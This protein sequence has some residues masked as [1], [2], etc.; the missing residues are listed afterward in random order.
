M[1]TG[2]SKMT[3]RE[4]RS[5]PRCHRDTTINFSYFN[6]V[7]KYSALARNYCHSGMYFETDRALATGVIILIRPEP[8]PENMPD[9]KSA[10]IY[11]TSRAADSAACQE[12]KTLVTAQ[13]KRCDKLSAESTYR[14]G[15]AVEYVGPSL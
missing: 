3:A 1:I 2:S 12:L 8:C 6:R 14:Y 11:C 7:E 13:V 10:P 15:V 5:H 9:N 4:K